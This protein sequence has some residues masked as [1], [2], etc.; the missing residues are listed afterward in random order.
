MIFGN[1][2]EPSLDLGYDTGAWLN[3]TKYR[4]GKEKLPSKQ[5]SNFGLG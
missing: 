1:C 5:E 3:L 4:K 2:S